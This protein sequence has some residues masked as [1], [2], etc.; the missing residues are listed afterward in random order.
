MKKSLIYILVFG[1]FSAFQFPEVINPDRPLSGEWDF[2]PKLL[3]KV[4]EAGP[5]L[6]GEIQ[7]LAVDSKQKVFVADLKHS[8]IFVYDQNGSYLK[9]FGKKG[10]GPGEIREYFG[11][12][13]LH[14][15]GN[16]VLFCDRTMIHYFDNDGNYLKTVQ[17]SQSLKPRAFID[18][19]TF[20][21]APATN[22]R[23]S[24]EPSQILLVDLNTGKRVPIASFRPFDKATSTEEDGDRQV[25]IG[26]VIGDITPLMLVHAVGNRIY[27]GMNDTYRLHISD[28]EGNTISDFSIPERKAN[29]VSDEYK[30][31]LGESLGDVPPN[32][33][34]KIMDGLPPHASFFSAIHVDKKGNIYLFESDPDSR[35]KKSV[36]IFNSKGEFIYR[37][38]FE[39]E[40][41]KSIEYL[42]IDDRFVLIVTE[43]EEGTVTLSKYSIKLPQ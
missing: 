15:V 22:D 24:R 18:E 4:D 30:K 13:Q 35:S 16:K 39:V 42:R 40:K 41:G 2:S 29:P 10:E 17:F 7:N 23:R 20:V 11:G 34:K 3:W 28:L 12:D 9:R 32:F 43:D 36:D 37:G 31:E 38:A 33:L 26:I 27:Y 21:S 8:Y 25:T 1:I 14:I 19:H 5:D 6:F